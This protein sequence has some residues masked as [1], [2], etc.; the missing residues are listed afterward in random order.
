MK[1]IGII[2]GTTWVSTQDY[3]KSINQRINKALGNYHS[4]RI[5][6][7]SINFEDVIKFKA[8][9]NDEALKKM[10]LDAANKLEYAGAD[11]LLLAANT[12]HMLADFIQLRIKIPLIHIGEETATVIA[13]DNVKKVGLLGTKTTMEEDFYIDKLKSHNIETIVPGQEEREYINRSIF[14]EFSKEIFAEDTRIR[15]GRIII[16]LEKQGAEGII[17]GCTEIPL[18]L[19][20]ELFKIPL[21]NTTEIHADAAVRFVLDN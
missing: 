19:K 6:L 16:E 2:G 14:D 4:A 18:L 5:I 3:Y 15:Y 11:C 21:F 8:E 1:T 20:N 12:M 10:M 7:Y 9:G 17:L 13:K